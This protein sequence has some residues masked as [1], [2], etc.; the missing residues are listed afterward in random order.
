MLCGSQLQLTKSPGLWEDTGGGQPDFP[1]NIGF[2]CQ[3]Q[4]SCISVLAAFADLMIQEA[5]ERD[6]FYT[7]L[8]I[9]RMSVGFSVGK[10]TTTWVVICLYN[11]AGDLDFV[12]FTALDVAQGPTH[13][14]EPPTL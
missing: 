7:C 6:K 3:R 9:L 4:V 13:K 1:A 11:V 10:R 12:Y 5:M 2:N 8:K 14:T